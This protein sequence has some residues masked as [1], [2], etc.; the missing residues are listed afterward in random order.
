[1]TYHWFYASMILTV[2]FILS[3]IVK[4]QDKCDPLS[5][6]YAGNK[7]LDDW[8]AAMK[9]GR[10]TAQTPET[11]SPQTFAAAQ[12]PIRAYRGASY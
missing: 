12:L 6:T 4:G 3:R 9:R 2:G 10:G 1:M 8:G 5:P 7:A 11:M